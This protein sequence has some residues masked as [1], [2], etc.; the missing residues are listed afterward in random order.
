MNAFLLAELSPGRIRTQPV[1]SSPSPATKD[2]E[3]ANERVAPLENTLSRAGENLLPRPARNE[4]GEG[5]GEG[6]LSNARQTIRC[7]LSPLLRRG[8]RE[9]DTSHPALPR[10]V[11]PHLPRTFGRLALFASLLVSA[12]IAPAAFAADAAPSGTIIS[13]AGFHHPGVLVN[14][15]QLDFVKAK[16]AAGAEPWKSAFDAAKASE[17]AALAYVPHP[18][19]TC[20]C[21]PR[22]NP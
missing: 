4:R 20:E 14:R 18:W 11:E 10:Q 1:S 16:I 19:A 9:Q 13:A 5:R 21:G 6:K 17:Q 8:A 3:K 7:P 15:A 22:S 12:A 2:R